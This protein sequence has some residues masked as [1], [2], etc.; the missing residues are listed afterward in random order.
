MSEQTVHFL[1]W[2]MIAAIWT[3]VLIGGWRTIRELRAVLRQRREPARSRR[4]V[5]HASI[6]AAR[7]F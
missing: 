5:S 1:G 6:M 2:V 3:F 4:V 7:R